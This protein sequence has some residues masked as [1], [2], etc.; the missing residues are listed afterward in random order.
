VQ[1]AALLNDCYGNPVS[2]GTAV[3]FSLVADSPWVSI[4]GSATV[5]NENTNGDSLL[6]TAFT[7]LTYE[8]SHTNDTVVISVEVSDFTDTDE[9]ILPIQFPVIDMVPVPMH[10]EWLVGS[11]ENPRYV[12]IWVTVKDGQNNPISNQEIVFSS[13]LGTPGYGAPYN[14]QTSYTGLTDQDGFLSQDYQFEY[15]ECPPSVPPPG[16][17]TPTINAQILGTQTQNNVTVILS[18]YH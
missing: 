5:G 14:F 11:D 17:K 10:V 18:N 16:I 2:N 9:V 13:D 15:Y 3:Y 6:G 12:E 1:V 8:G 4:E 7:F